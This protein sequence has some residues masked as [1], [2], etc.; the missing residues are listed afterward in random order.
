[1]QRIRR[2]QIGIGLVA[3]CLAVS[4]CSTQGPVVMLDTTTGPIVLRSPS[5]PSMPDG[6]AGPPPGLE[7]TTPVPPPGFAEGLPVSRSGSYSGTAEVLMTNGGLCREN[8]TVSG[9]KVSGNTAR[10]GGF[11]GTIEPNGNIQMFYGSEWIVGQFEG[12]TFRGQL[13]LPSRSFGPGCSYLLSLQR[14][15][16]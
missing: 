8:L 12:A 5:A 13:D 9:F 3:I 16:P 11:R 1:M 6:M 4:G 10:F 7:P 2:V 14:V 15:G